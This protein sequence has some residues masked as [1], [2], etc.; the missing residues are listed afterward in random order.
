VSFASS[1]ASARNAAL[2]SGSGVLESFVVIPESLC[3][4][5]C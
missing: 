4:V 5:F 2:N 3:R 1:A